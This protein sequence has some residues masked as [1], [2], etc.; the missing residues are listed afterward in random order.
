MS[1]FVSITAPGPYNWTAPETGTVLVQCVGGGGGGGPGLG[2]VSGRGGGGGAA[3]AAARLNVV[4][5]RTYT[6]VVA[7]GGSGGIFVGQTGA[8]GGGDSTFLDGATVR[9][10]A[11]GGA[12]ATAGP[13]GAGGDLADCI[14]DTRH[15]GFAGQA[16]GGSGGGSYSGGEGGKAG[17]PIGG[18]GGK[19]QGQGS[20]LP[21][22]APG[23]GGAGGGQAS[24]NGGAGANGV[25]LISYVDTSLTPGHYVVDFTVPGVNSWVAPADGEVVVECY[26]GGGGARDGNG[27]AG[28]QG[29]AGGG[30]YS[31]AV[32]QVT[33]GTSYSALVGAAGVRGS[34]VGTNG[35]DS[36]FSQGATTLVLAKGGSGSTTTTGAP[37]GQA[38]AGIG[39]VRNS[40]FGG[41]N[42]DSPA[43]YGG[44][45]GGAGALPNGGKGGQAGQG[46]SGTALANGTAPG[47]GG[48]GGSGWTGSLSGGNGAPGKVTIGYYLHYGYTIIDREQKFITSVSQVRGGVKVPLAVSRITGG[49]RRYLA[50]CSMDLTITER[51][52][53]PWVPAGYESRFHQAYGTFNWNSSTTANLRAALA[54]AATA[55]AHQVFVGDSVTEGWNYL[56]HM[57]PY[58][59][60]GD[61]LHSWPIFTRE[62]INDMVGLPDGGTGFVRA[63]S[64]Q[65]FV[66]PRWT[67]SGSWT[68][69]VHYVTTTSGTATFA[70]N[71]DGDG[72][73]VI[74]LAGGA[75]QVSVD[76]GAPIVI[77]ATTGPTR[78]TLTGLA[79]T[80]H[81]INI[82]S[83]TGAQINLAGAEVFNTEGGIRTHNVAQGG[84]K[85][86]GVGQDAW[87]DSSGGVTGNMLPLYTQSANTWGATPQT[88]FVALGGNDIHSNTDYGVIAAALDT[89]GQAFDGPNTDI[90]LITVS[91]G[92]KTFSTR[93][94]V[95][96]LANTY[97][98][99]LD[100]NWPLIDL[101]FITG[102]YE[103]MAG[104]GYTGDV[105]GHLNVKGAEFVGN[106]IGRAL[107]QPV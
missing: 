16:N 69:N 83:N 19:I 9:V 78:F 64:I 4:Q 80:T 41:L 74:L 86:A 3:Y 47:G 25:V 95:P 63:H 90:V 65:N 29:G 82:R 52:P 84:A 60:S 106:A 53:P 14:G 11:K 77:P 59:A 67:Y 38:S 6:G 61:L 76:G 98:L 62:Y 24:G 93:D 102:G 44:G 66:D 104:L 15:S 101:E 88:V 89:I 26:A 46:I 87:S 85:A 94:I 21:G 2:L 100:R 36:S 45:A 107:L 20:G 79:K 55:P 97:Q 39:Q 56:N 54:N 75:V 5:G 92:S 58:N 42:R 51:T 48:G 57:P 17:G 96:L 49:A 70:S 13:G 72:I 1:D 43:T 37:G 10:L 33:R 34:T 73:A 7:A 103:S 50:R 71:K 27:V 12:P 32:V 18:A 8:T 91:H 40:G 28:G 22:T 99:A 23:G 105:Y 81:T 35:G 30:A 31:M 68:N